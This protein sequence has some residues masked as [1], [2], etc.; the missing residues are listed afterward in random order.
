MEKEQVIE[1]HAR[2][3]T[4]EDFRQISDAE[5]EAKNLENSLNE[6]TKHEEQADKMAE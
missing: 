1:D 6:V 4:N 5:I 2:L 3:Q